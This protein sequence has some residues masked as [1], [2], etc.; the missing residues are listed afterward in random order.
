MLFISLVIVNACLCVVAVPF[1]LCCCVISRG[2][3]TAL[4]IS[5]A[6]QSLR[7]RC[8]YSVGLRQE[9]QSP[10][11][12]LDRRVKRCSKNFSN[13]DEKASKLGFMTD[14]IHFHRTKGTAHYEAS[15]CTRLLLHTCMTEFEMLFLSKELQEQDY[16]SFLFED[17]HACKICLLLFAIPE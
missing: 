14:F 17:V 4:F 2:K 15:T 8:H 7:G 10:P 16:P 1:I 5:P 6:L 12:E 11:F 3:Y 13:D 9:D